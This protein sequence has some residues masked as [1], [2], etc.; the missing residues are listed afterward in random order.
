MF[1]IVG[2]CASF[3]A[4]AIAVQ[5]EENSARFDSQE[6]KPIEVVGSS[7]VFSMNHFRSLSS[8]NQFLVEIVRVHLKINIFRFCC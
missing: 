4:F 8:K 3:Q 2:I 7:R 5:A 6:A 1:K